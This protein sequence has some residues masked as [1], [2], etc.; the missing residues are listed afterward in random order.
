MSQTSLAELC[1]RILGSLPLADEYCDLPDVHRELVS[2]LNLRLS[3]SRS[4]SDKNVRLKT[5]DSFTPATVQHN[6][7]ALIGDGEPAWIET[8]DDDGNYYPI[9]VVNLSEL[10]YY[11][12]SLACAFWAEDTTAETATEP[13]RYVTFTQVPSAACRIRYDLDF[14]KDKLAQVSGMPEHT[15]DLVI[16]ETENA[17]IQKVIKTKLALDLRGNEEVRQDYRAIVDS[18]DGYYKQNMMDIPGLVALWKIWAFRNPSTQTSFT[19]PT[20]S[21]RNLY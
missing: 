13:V 2:K 8:I 11:E 16:K 20:P 1:S 10:I 7:T 14:V 3:Q 17:L 21:S 6:I 15:E 18:L 5:S 4:G 9:R 12:G 19:K